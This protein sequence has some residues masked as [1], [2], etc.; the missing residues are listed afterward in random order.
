VSTHRRLDI[1]PEHESTRRPQPIPSRPMLIGTRLQ[2]SVIDPLIRLAF[3]MGIPD[4][5]DALL[6]TTG[7]QS[8]QPQ[9]TPICDGLEG[10]TF[11]LVSQRGREADWVRNIEVDPRVRV[12]L[13]SRRPPTWRSGTAHI[14]EDDD[15]PA[16]SRMLSR[17]RPWR[18]LCLRAAA[19]LAINPLTVRIDLDPLG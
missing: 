6:E 3:R 10:N 2:S 7:R 19:M 12:Q 9:F 5:G 13:R 15:A 18:Q 4:P 11:W 17:G 8:G 16:R 1:T 14:A